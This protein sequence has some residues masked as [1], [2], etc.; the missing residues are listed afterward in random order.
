MENPAKIIEE[1]QKEEHEK[2]WQEQVKFNFE[3][4][5]YAK[6]FVKDLYST[7][8]KL[9]ENLEEVSKIVEGKGGPF[10]IF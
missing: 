2:V 5:E 3:K 8:R 1:K 10:D 9:T 4:K 6:H 7:L